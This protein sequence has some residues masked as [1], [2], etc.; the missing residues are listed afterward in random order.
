MLKIIIIKHNFYSAPPTSLF[1]NVLSPMNN[2]VTSVMRVSTAAVAL[3]YFAVATI[4]LPTR[5]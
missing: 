4:A 2:K 1:I 3:L 5:E